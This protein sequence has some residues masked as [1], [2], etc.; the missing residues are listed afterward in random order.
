MVR[1]PMIGMTFKQGPWPKCIGMDGDECCQY[2]MTYAKDIQDNC[3]LVGPDEAVTEDFN[4]KRVRVYV[5]NDSIVTKAP[6][7]G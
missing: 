6:S 1:T 4:T 3:V 2:I 5:D 7:R